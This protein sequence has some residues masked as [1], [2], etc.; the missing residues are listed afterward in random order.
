MDS[1]LSDLGR[2][3]LRLSLEPPYRDLNSNAMKCGPGSSNCTLRV[4]S[5]SSADSALLSVSF[6]SDAECARVGAA[7]NVMSVSSTATSTFGT[8]G[9]TSPCLSLGAV[10][11]AFESASSWAERLAPVPRRANVFHR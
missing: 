9:Y 5:L 6:D 1:I 7:S 2:A 11:V 4:W 10:D 8:S 3:R